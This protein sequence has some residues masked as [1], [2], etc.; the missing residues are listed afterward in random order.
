MSGHRDWN[1]TE[2]ESPEDG[3]VVETMDSGGHVQD[4]KKKGNLWWL[5]D[6]SMYVYFIPMFW[7]PK[8]ES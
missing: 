6:D 3:V 8:D 5:A 2:K 4:M 7:K 1:L